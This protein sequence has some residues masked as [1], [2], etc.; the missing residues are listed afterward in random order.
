MH[1]LKRLRDSTVWGQVTIPN[2]LI[3][4]AVGLVLN[5]WPVMLAKP[6]DKGSTQDFGCLTLPTNFSRSRPRRSP[7]LVGHSHLLSKVEQPS[8]DP[9]MP[10]NVTTQLGQT[11]YLHCK[12]HNLGDKTPSSPQ[13][14][15]GVSLSLNLL[16]ST[17][18]GP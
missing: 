2:V 4:I 5:A 15:K 13:L 7:I 17:G 3:W 12:V 10:K 18:N 9:A 6:G 16:G 1:G 8:F 14:Q 11:V